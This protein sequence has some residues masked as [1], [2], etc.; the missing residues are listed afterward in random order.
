MPTITNPGVIP[1]LVTAYLVNDCNQS[2]AGMAIGYTEGYVYNGEYSKL[3]DRDDVIA[4]LKRQRLE[5]IAKT[6]FT[7]EDAHAQIDE[8]RA[9][10]RSK[11]Q[12]AA[13]VTST[14]Q[15]VRLY[16]MDQMAES[17]TG[18]TINV[19]TDRKVIDSKEID[20]V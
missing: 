5:L 11:G 15:K 10:A 18:L 3:W 8:D 7:K 13:A 16:G 14:G 19:T 9:Y 20:N 1:A 12:A 4:E 2:K 6:G 17:S